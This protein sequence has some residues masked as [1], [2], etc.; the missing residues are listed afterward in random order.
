MHKP[1]PEFASLAGG[2][3]INRIP[4]TLAALGVGLYN[5]VVCSKAAHILLQSPRG[6]ITTLRTAR[7]RHWDTCRLTLRYVTLHSVVSYQT[8]SH[9]QEWIEYRLS[10]VHCRFKLNDA[11]AYFSSYT[12]CCNVQ[13]MHALLRDQECSNA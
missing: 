9:S 4:R 8:E 6:N 5:S 7:L 3:W 1:V 13:D 12:Y 2:N 11:P 10:L